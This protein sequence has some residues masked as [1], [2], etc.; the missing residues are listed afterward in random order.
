MYDPLQYTIP[1]KLSAEHASIKNVVWS[2]RAHQLSAAVTAAALAAGLHLVLQCSTNTTA[3][4]A[5]AVTAA[6]LS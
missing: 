5:A 6:S 4:A 1:S 2:A 3:A